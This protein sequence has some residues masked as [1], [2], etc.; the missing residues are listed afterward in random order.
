MKNNQLKIG[1]AEAYWNAAG[2]RILKFTVEMYHKGLNEHKL[3]SAPDEEILEN[4]ANIQAN[5]WQIKWTKL[6]AKRKK[7]ESKQA[8]MENA[9]EKDNEAQQALRDIDNIL[10]HTLKIND[11]IDWDTLKKKDQFSEPLPQKPA[12]RIKRAYNSKP[13]ISEP[14]FTPELTFMDKLFK[15]KKERK[16][17]ECERKYAAA[18][19]DWEKH[20][21]EVVDYNKKIDISH[22]N[23]INKYVKAVEDWE[24]RKT[25]FVSNQNKYN[26][27]IDNL[28]KA[29]LNKSP[30]AVSEYCELVLNNS[31]YPETF[32]QNFELEYVPETKILVV[33]YEMPS[34]KCLPNVKE[35]KYIASKKEI[36][37]YLVSQTQ[38]NNMF[39]QTLYKIA[40]RSIHE[41]FEADT[42]DAIDAI[43]FNGWVIE[44]N[45]ATGKEENNCIL[46]IQT[47]KNEF[48]NID[49]G[50]VDPKICFKGL[51]GVASTKLSSITPIQPILRISREDKR[52]VESYE[53]AK[54]LDNATNIAA[55]DWEDFEHLIRELFEKEFQQNG[56][57]VKVTQASRDGGVDAIAFDPDPIR[58]GKIVIQAKRYTN[59]VGVAAVRDLYG[60]VVNE[61][62]TKGILVST[63]DYGSDAYNFAK[64][65]P[66]TLLNGSNLLHLLEKHGHHAKIDLREAKKML[67]DNK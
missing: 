38:I 30:E 19:S 9:I 29:Y 53:V 48:I 49:L 4:K 31:T 20:Y 17:R 22:Q 67:A 44:V 6:E 5:K 12:P 35:V 46:S 62:A 61:G 51:K 36:K 58:G 11:S 33:E 28:K 7:D 55:M 37:E 32:P 43:S 25:N 63:A 34:V 40:L 54:N 59:T 16:I 21:A 10:K 18:C 41:I 8:N 47:T 1:R 14:A 65:K 24:K 60:T 13:E 23:E 39:D 56:G 3:I 26:L 66:L 2:T 64:D 42:I 45:K 15:S 50:N 57:E 52:F 27:K